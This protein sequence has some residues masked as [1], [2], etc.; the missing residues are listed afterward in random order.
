MK[1]LRFTYYIIAFIF[2]CLLFTRSSM[3]IA[4]DEQS[5]VF[6]AMQDELQRTVSKLKLEK[7]KPPYYVAYGIIDEEKTTVRGQFGA[8]ITDHTEHNRYLY[9]DL[10]VGNYDFDNS[11]F[12]SS[13]DYEYGMSGD[14]TELPLDDDYDAI[15]Q[16]I[17]LATDEQYKSAV[18]EM[19]KK[20]STIEHKQMKD[21]IPDFSKVTPYQNFDEIKKTTFD[22]NFWRENIKTISNTFKTYSKLQTS[23]VDFLSRTR[24][25]YFIDSDGNKFVKN[26]ASTSLEAVANTQ[27]KEGVGLSNYVGFYT[28]TPEELPNI[29]VIVD[30]VKGMADTLSLYTQIPEENEYSGPVM[31][32]SL[33]SPQL[34]YEIIGKGV[35]DVRKPMYE[36]EQMSEMLDEKTGFL[37]GKFEKDVLPKDFSVSDDPSLTNWNGTALIGNYTVDDQGVKADKI[38]LVKAGKLINLP[39][40]RMPTKEIKKSNGHG[41]YFGGKVKNSISNLIISS[42][43]T[44]D[45]LE[46][47]FI[48]LLKAKELD[49]GIVITQLAFQIPKSREEMMDE[50]SFFFGGSKSE[51][52]LISAPLIT[53]KLYTDGKK[54]L[55]SGLKFDAVAPMVLKD[56]VFTGIDQTV[57]NFFL[58]ERF[59]DAHLPIS[60]IAPSVIID[61]MI[62]ASKEGKAKKQPYLTHPYFE[63]K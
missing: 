34:F 35:T 13:P 55:I 50:F 45:N 28:H 53:Y 8:I 42:D 9:I 52:P 4:K 2:Y 27:N 38:E 63:K 43:K 37:A 25:I 12:V 33:A 58:K 48:N 1:K 23:K 20:K 6:Q 7:E 41:R 57:Y 19:A 36:E 32:T 10:R 22:K 49:Y 39:M 31:F 11:N 26:N 18:D 5:P 46:N 29:N 17:W 61:K 56:I 24:T 44:T 21:T 14:I 60:I 59:G 15:R 40:S 51:T 16:K 54:E 62:L 30:R 3:L 47:E